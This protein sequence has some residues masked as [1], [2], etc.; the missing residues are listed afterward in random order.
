MDEDKALARAR[1]RAL[2]NYID[3]LKG[4][5]YDEV[6]IALDLGI[7]E[8]DLRS[9]Y[10]S[11]K[12]QLHIEK[13]EVAQR[14]RDQGSSVPNIARYMGISEAQVIVLIGPGKTKEK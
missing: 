3:N 6:E 13:V 1:N 2:T 14:L 5:G 12:E 11:A 8:A 7:N 4:R 9:Y 10:K